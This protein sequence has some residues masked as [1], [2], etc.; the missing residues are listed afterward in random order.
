MF[1]SGPAVLDVGRG[2][3]EEQVPCV[4]G[5]VAGRCRARQ[6]VAGEP[7][8]A[9]GAPVCRAQRELGALAGERDDDF[10]GVGLGEHRVTEKWLT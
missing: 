2:W 10:T 4:G 3:A 9:E 8:S 6:L 7:S 5:R 1:T